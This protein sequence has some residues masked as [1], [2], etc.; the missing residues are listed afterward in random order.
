[1]PTEVST[2]HS[3]MVL[4][5]CY[6][7]NNVY[8]LDKIG[9]ILYITSPTKLITKNWKEGIQARMKIGINPCSKSTAATVYVY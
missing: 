3:A 5:L 1:M 9:L 6:I 2:E 7:I 8:E 4:K